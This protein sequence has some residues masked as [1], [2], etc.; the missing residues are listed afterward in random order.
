MIHDMAGSQTSAAHAAPDSTARD[1]QGKGLRKPRRARPEV[2]ARADRFGAECLAARIPFRDRLM[3]WTYHVQLA[4]RGE[5]V[6]SPTH[7]AVYADG[8]WKRGYEKYLERINRRLAKTPRP[9][10]VEVPTFAH[11]E[12]TGDDLELLLDRN[13][14]FLIK[15]GARDVAAKDWTL[16]YF[17][18]HAGDCD[19]P[20]N[21][22]LDLPDEDT[23]RP[24]K[25]H[26]YYQFKTGKLSDVVRS[27][28]AGGPARI[29]TAEDVMHADGGR[30]RRD[31]DLPYWEHM[32][33]WDRN[34]SHWL[35]SKF[36]VGQVVG[37]QLMMQPEGAITIWH[38]EPGGNFFVLA[39]GTKTWTLAHPYYTAGLR[40]RVKTTT[41][42]FGCNIDVRESDEVQRSRGFDGYLGIPR[43]TVPM[44]PGDVLRVPNHWWHT[45]VTHPGSYA[46]AATIRTECMPNLTGPGMMVLRWL[47]TQFHQIARDFAKEGRIS[48]KHIGF[49]RQSRSVEETA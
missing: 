20:V 7:D 9:E 23:S 41:N 30:F 48:D 16:D 19:V 47:D 25:A 5:Q 37:A 1:P 31:L 43:V 42:Y 36:L 40:P 22:A 15:D 18:E 6:F 24:T 8:F 17:D 35:R 2:R 44:E 4:R 12:L 45:A 33:G 3:Y 39:K 29:S 38:A 26:H 11:G 14:P 13:I 10:P 34:R 32:S 28:H 49:P 21:E 27:I 46:I